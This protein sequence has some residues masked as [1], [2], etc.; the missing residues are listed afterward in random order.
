M[1]KKR[2]LLK[3]VN[4]SPIQ[5]PRIAKKVPPR[6][7]TCKPG[8]LEQLERIVDHRLV[9]DRQQAFGFRGRHLGY[10]RPFARGHD[11]RLEFQP[12]LH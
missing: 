10:S 3:I 1:G 4:F 11:D 2:F 12:I 6:R 7:F 5:T 8:A 9:A